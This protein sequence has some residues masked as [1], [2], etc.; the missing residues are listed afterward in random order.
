MKR[1]SDKEIGE[2]REIGMYSISDTSL[3]FVVPIDGHD[4][5]SPVVLQSAAW[6][7][8]VV[9]VHAQQPAN[10][11]TRSWRRFAREV[12]YGLGYPHSQYARL[13]LQPR[14]VHVAGRDTVLDSVLVCLAKKCLTHSRASR[15]GAYQ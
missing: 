3:S 9:A 1:N 14:R 15:V 13:S 7:I 8:A 5:S 12:P 4:P 2:H 6:P 11:P 10:I